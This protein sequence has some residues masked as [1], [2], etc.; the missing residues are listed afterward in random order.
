MQKIGR[1][2]SHIVCQ[3]G[4]QQAR[5]PSHRHHTQGYTGKIYATLEKLTAR[6]T[7]GPLRSKNFL[8]VLPLDVD[9][10]TALLCVLCG[11]NDLSLPLSK[12]REVTLWSPPPH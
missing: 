10:C 12:K 9:G 8:A 4:P 6:G 2:R 1:R 5:Y 7:P 3:S 11:G